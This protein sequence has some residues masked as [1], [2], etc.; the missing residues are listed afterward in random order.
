M[1]IEYNARAVSSVLV[2]GGCVSFI[3]ERFI[4]ARTLLWL[5]EHGNGWID[6]QRFPTYSD[7]GRLTVVNGVCLAPTYSDAPK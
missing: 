6:R 3:V 5:I 2:H 1:D 4:R 7:R